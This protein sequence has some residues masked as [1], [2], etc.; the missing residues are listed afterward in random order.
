MYGNV[1]ELRSLTR[2]QYL[3]IYGWTRNPLV[4]YYVLEAFG[5]YNPVSGDLQLIED[6]LIVL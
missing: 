3:A 1:R 4:E 5:E 6:F 2:N